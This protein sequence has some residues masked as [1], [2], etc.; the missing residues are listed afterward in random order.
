ME[1]GAEGVEVEEGVEEEEC[2]PEV[3][4]QEEEEMQSSWEQNHLP[5]VGIVKMSTDSFQ[6]SRDIC[7]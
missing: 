5:S 3:Q 4:P 7:P 1:E 2:Q 6:T